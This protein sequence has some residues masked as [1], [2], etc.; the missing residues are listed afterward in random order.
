MV[1]LNLWGIFSLLF[2]QLQM[3]FFHKIMVAE[4]FFFSFNA[5]HNFANNKVISKC[6]YNKP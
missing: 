1:Y 5:Y 4:N 6:K 2:R 3:T